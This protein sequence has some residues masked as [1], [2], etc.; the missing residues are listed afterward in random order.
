MLNVP[1]NVRRIRKR[2]RLQTRSRRSGLI[3]HAY[4][5]RRGATISRST[6]GGGP[7]AACV[8]ALQ[9]RRAIRHPVENTSRRISRNVIYSRSK[10]SASAT[11]A[12]KKKMETSLRG[13]RAPGLR[14]LI[15]KRSERRLRIFRDEFDIKIDIGKRKIN[16]RTTCIIII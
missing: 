9:Y 14:D 13:Y 11:R 4:R 10:K 8:V 12:W 16:F 2:L 6:G 15:V 5:R 3:I 7:S 1:L